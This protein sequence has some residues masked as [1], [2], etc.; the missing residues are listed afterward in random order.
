MQMETHGEIDHSVLDS[1]FRCLAHPTR[2][3]VLGRLQEGGREPVSV[4]ELVDHVV[5]KGPD[6]SVD[7]PETAG[8]T[9]YHTHLPMLVEKGLVDYDRGRGIVSPTARLGQIEPYLSVIPSIDGFDAR[10]GD[11]R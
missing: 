8:M 6:D 2:R 5:T 10:S 4:D 11:D 3:A 7:D 1:L 9:L